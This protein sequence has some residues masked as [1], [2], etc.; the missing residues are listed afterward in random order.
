VQ[1]PP[2]VKRILDITDLGGTTPE[3]SFLMITESNPQLILS[4]LR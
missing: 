3:E 1:I 2:S 4:A